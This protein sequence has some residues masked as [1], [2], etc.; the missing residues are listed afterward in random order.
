MSSHI[1]IV[2]R[3]SIKIKLNE[4]WNR[5][6]YFFVQD[7]FQQ[8]F[9]HPTIYPVLLVDGE[10][11]V[12]VEILAYF[13]PCVEYNRWNSTFDIWNNPLQDLL[14]V[15]FQGRVYNNG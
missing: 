5:N 12:E 13:V 9:Y 6:Y 14:L 10:E 3:A 8:F 1:D 11:L 4:I 15:I 7:G 2:L